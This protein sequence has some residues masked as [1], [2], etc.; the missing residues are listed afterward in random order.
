MSPLRGQH[1]TTME[2]DLLDRLKTLCAHMR[3]IFL[4][5]IRPISQT[6][7]TWFKV[8]QSIFRVFSR[9]VPGIVVYDLFTVSVVRS[10]GRWWNQDCVIH[11]LLSDF[12][13]ATFFNATFF[14]FSRNPRSPKP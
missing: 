12:F 3:S 14:Q 4:Q 11:Y 6:I 2:S 7:Q 13:D 10:A 5:F 8:I 9:R 1:S